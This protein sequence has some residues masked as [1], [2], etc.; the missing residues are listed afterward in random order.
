M[1]KDVSSLLERLGK[2][3]LRYRQFADPIADL[4]PWPL[5]KALLTDPR[6]VGAPSTGVDKVRGTAA[7][8]SGGILGGYQD[9]GAAGRAG[10]DGEGPQGLRSFL[11]GLGSAPQ[12]RDT[13]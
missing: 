5:F 8:A 13:K 11:K 6:I 3:D 2:Q 10:G 12:G 1:R 4:E 7:D 9:G